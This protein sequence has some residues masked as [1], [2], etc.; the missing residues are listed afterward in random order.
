M[1][2][3][4][5]KLEEMCP[6][7][8]LSVELP[9]N[10][11]GNVYQARTTLAEGL[12]FYGRAETEEDAILKCCSKAV[13]HLQKN[14]PE[15]QPKSASRAPS[16]KPEISKREMEL[17]GEMGDVLDRVA[18]WNSRYDKDYGSKRLN[19]RFNLIF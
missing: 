18:Q 15:T 1:E 4:R 6:N 19:F 11:N 7:V 8:T 17:R 5:S 14:G 13:K 2:D 9:H 10:G 12:I 3:F 16:R